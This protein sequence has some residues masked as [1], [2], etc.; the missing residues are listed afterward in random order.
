MERTILRVRD[1]LRQP[2]VTKAGAGNDAIVTTRSE[3]YRIRCSIPQVRVSSGREPMK[4]A[5]ARRG[6][7]TRGH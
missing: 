5:C 1:L 3:G 4:E 6:I 2:F 7:G